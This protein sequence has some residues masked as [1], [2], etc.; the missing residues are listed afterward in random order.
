M[1][2]ELRIYQVK[3][4]QSATYIDHFA[5]IGLPIVNK[6]MFLAGFWQT[7]IGPLNEILHLWE[8]KDYDHRT[9]VRGRLHRD[10]AWQRDFLPK[11]LELIVGQRN[12]LLTPTAFSP[13]FNSGLSASEPT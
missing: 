13:T 6:Y 11:A 10:E 12:M 2:Q 9:L 7:D 8:F 3:V 5:K 1:L 4:G